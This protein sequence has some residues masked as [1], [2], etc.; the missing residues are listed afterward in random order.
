M[1]EIALACGLFLL[2]A[3]T[4]V[5]I[6]LADWGLLFYAGAFLLVAGLG[7]SVPCALRYHLLLRD[8]LRPRGALDRHWIWNPTGHHP[9]L[10]PGERARVLP[11]FYAGAAGWGASVLGC[12]LI[13]LA[14][15]AFR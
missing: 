14:T 10:T 9:R 5:V 11:W 7:L 12:L 4:A 8:A 15:L 2:L 1:R 13:G 3:A 6:R